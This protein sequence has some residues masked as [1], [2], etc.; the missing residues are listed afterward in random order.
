M[1]SL[2]LKDEKMHHACLPRAFKH[3]SE[4][5]Q[6]SRIRFYASMLHVVRIWTSYMVRIWPLY[7][8]CV[9]LPSSTVYFARCS[10]F[11]DVHVFT[12]YIPALIPGQCDS[13]TSPTR[14]NMYV[15]P[16]LCQ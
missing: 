1:A 13:T 6:S 4:Q 9:Y 5:A 16:A 2:P 3:Y 10:V 14:C 8:E 7:D 11:I 12:S 15:L